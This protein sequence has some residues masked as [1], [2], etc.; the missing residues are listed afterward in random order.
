M[1]I[2]D[3][4]IHLWQNSEMRAQHRQIPTY[5]AD[6]ALAEMAS[7]GVDRA[8]I[9]PPSALGEAV[10]VLA[11]EAVR[12]HPD[13]FC[14]RA[15]PTRSGTSTAICVRSSRRSGLSARS[16]APTSPACRARTGSA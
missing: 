3:S 5:S 9:H 7:A 15:S 12:Q 2:V 11:V 1:L 8:V 6:D 14:I 13:K 16:G 10:N 4:Q